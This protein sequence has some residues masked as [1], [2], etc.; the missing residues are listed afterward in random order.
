M[1]GTWRQTCLR[2]RP[3]KKI[4]GRVEVNKRHRS[5][6]LDIIIILPKHL[7]C[8]R[9]SSLPGH[10]PYFLVL[11]FY[12]MWIPPRMMDC[13]PGGQ[14]PSFS[15]THFLLCCFSKDNPCSLLLFSREPCLSSSPGPY[16]SPPTFSLPA[17]ACLLF[18][19]KECLP[20]SSPEAL[21]GIHFFIQQIFIQSLQLTWHEIMHEILVQ[22]IKVR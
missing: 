6:N 10:S 19:S 20:G 15:F 21:L 9:S 4:R 14:L 3:P 8:P 5:S 17:F 11:S 16:S 2:T 1:A 22:I 7:P 12:K 18:S 13:F